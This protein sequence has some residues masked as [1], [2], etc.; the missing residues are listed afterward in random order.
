M[1]L[2]AAAQVHIPFSIFRECSQTNTKSRSTTNTNSNKLCPAPN[3]RSLVDTAGVR[4]V[5]HRTAA[6]LRHM[7]V[8]AVV[9]VAIYHYHHHDRQH[10]FADDDFII[11]IANINIRNNNDDIID[12]NTDIERSG[13]CVVACAIAQLRASTMC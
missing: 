4:A 5:S 12:N 13:V 8:V 1:P 11:N 7:V 3:R 2:S 6:A 9:V 10:I